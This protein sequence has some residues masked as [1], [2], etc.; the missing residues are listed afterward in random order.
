MG[1]MYFAGIKKD[2]A[3]EGLIDTEG[4]SEY[5]KCIMRSELALYSVIA[6][7]YPVLLMHRTLCWGLLCRT[8]IVLQ[9]Y[10]I[11]E[12]TE[13]QRGCDRLLNSG[14]ER[15][16]SPPDS[17]VGLA[18]NAT[19]AGPCLSAGTALPFVMTWAHVGSFSDTGSFAHMNS[20]ECNTPRYWQQ[21][22]LGRNM[23]I[24]SSFT[25]LYFVIFYN[26]L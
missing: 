5:V 9:P 4:Y 19:P 25:F 24:F 12:E 20:L 17:V 10:F 2:V 7:L 23:D 6:C 21:L 8:Y 26:G 22:F 14:T 13:V 18:G 16:R 1:K 3:E 11:G 15:S